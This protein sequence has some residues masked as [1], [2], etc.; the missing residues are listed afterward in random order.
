MTKPA[1]S[2]KTESDQSRVEGDAS[3][4]W[5]SPGVIPRAAFPAELFQGR[6][7][8]LKRNSAP[9]GAS[10]AQG[11]RGHLNSSS[12][13]CVTSS[14]SSNEPPSSTTLALHSCSGE[15]PQ[16]RLLVTK[17]NLD[18][19]M[20]RLRLDFMK[21]QNEENSHLQG[22]RWGTRCPVHQLQE[23]GRMRTENQALSP[24]AQTP[25]IAP[26]SCHHSAVR[27]LLFSSLKKLL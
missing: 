27:S 21:L 8:C 12:L 7:E 6:P 10:Q 19:L 25:H 24:A 4:Q 9:G 3:R 16:T 1:Q 13:R 5:A 14:T 23:G 26:P 22:Q 17:D 20:T 15:V 11:D 18:C 2:A